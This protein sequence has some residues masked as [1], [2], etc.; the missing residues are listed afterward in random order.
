MAKIVFCEDEALLQKLIHFIMRSTKHEVYIASDGLEGFALIEG[1][2][3]DLIL[4][5]ISMP[6]WDGFQLADAVKARP[7]LASIPIIF[8]TAF[9]QRIDVEEGALHGATGYLLKPFSAADLRATIEAALVPDGR[10]SRG[11]S[12]EDRRSTEKY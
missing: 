11:G 12:D 10:C 4:T 1:E 5:D 7:H 9:A 6:G 8:V 3:P 2:R